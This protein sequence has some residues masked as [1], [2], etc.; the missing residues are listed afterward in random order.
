MERLWYRVASAISRNNHNLSWWH[1]RHA[2]DNALRQGTMQCQE[3]CRMVIDTINLPDE[4]GMQGRNCKCKGT[5][6][7][8][9]LCP[10]LPQLWS[11][12]SSIGNQSHNN[13][14]LLVCQN[15]VWPVT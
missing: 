15:K 10:L 2:L 1:L 9:N 14:H 12:A 4:G 6:S 13:Q 8:Q 3:T 7:I 11:N 5:E